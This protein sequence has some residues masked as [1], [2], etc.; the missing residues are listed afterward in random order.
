MII[1]VLDTNFWHEASNDYLSNAMSLL[2]KIKSTPD[3]S[4]AIDH[5][6]KILDEYNNQINAEFIQRWVLKVFAYRADNN[7]I[8]WASSNLDAKIRQHLLTLNFEPN[9][10]PFTGL[11]L[12]TGKIIITEDSDY[13]VGDNAKATDE[14]KQ[15]IKDY[16]ESLGMRILDIKK[17]YT[18]YVIAE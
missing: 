10:L 17:A 8:Y 9:D 14:N 4:I 5:E 15:N 12:N 7:G 16:L 3:I 2:H 11:A 1:L 6:H 18:L 13:G